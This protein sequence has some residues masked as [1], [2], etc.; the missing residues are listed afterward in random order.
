MTESLWALLALILLHVLILMALRLRAVPRYKSAL[1]ASNVFEDGL[2]A[3]LFFLLFLPFYLAWLGAKDVRV[4]FWP[5]STLPIHGDDPVWS[6]KINRQVVETAFLAVQEAQ[7]KHNP[8]VARK[9]ISH[10]LYQRLRHDCDHPRT[11]HEVTPDKNVQI[12]EVV[13][14]DERI[15][16]NAGLCYFNAKVSGTI[17][18]GVNNDESEDFAVQLEFARALPRVQDARW[19]L[20]KMSGI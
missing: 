4:Q 15:E 18:T 9:F 11:D 12:L 6:R 3:G 10:E 17:S 16:E 13:V 8:N 5:P 14:S 2:L 1:G 7:M 19:Q 20:M